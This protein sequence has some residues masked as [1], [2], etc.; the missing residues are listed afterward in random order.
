VLVGREQRRTNNSGMIE[1]EAPQLMLMGV[2]IPP[3]L[4]VP[5]TCKAKKA[6]AAACIFS[7]LACN[8]S[9]LLTIVCSACWMCRPLL[10]INYLHN[11]SSSKRALGKEKV[12]TPESPAPPAAAAT[13]YF[14]KGDD[15][16]GR[17]RRRTL[18]LPS[19]CGVAHR[20]RNRRPAC[21]TGGL[22]SFPAAASW[23]R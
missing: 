11:T 4:P 17:M 12:A 9:I 19:T 8:I 1:R 10:D 15:N 3:Q 22:A 13:N 18:S 6:K 16:A 14:K 23:R 7:V 21:S 5:V 20:G 2:V